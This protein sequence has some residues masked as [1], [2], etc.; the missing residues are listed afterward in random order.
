MRKIPEHVR[1]MLAEDEWMKHCCLGDEYC[2]G[3]IEWHHNLIYAGRQSDIPE[4]ILPLCHFHHGCVGQ[5]NFKELLDWI[6]LC[7]MT[8]EQVQSIS[9]ATFYGF[10]KK[11]LIEKFGKQYTAR[12]L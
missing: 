7:R 5:H 2:S 6:M 9:K 11:Y 12:S 1:S 3:R 8:D 4:T 10:R